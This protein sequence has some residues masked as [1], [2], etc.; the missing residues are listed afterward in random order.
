LAYDVPKTPED[1][2]AIARVRNNEY[3]TRNL[4]YTEI[5]WAI[6]GKLPD[7]FKPLFADETEVRLEIRTLRTAD[8]D[9]TALT[10]KV[11][12]IEVAA[13]S[14]S[15]AA[16]DKDEKVE[17][18]AYGWNHGSSMRGGQEM[19]S[20]M[21]QL[22]RHQVRFGDGC[23]E[24]LPDHD[25]KLV[26]FNVVDPRNH[27]Y[28]IGYT[29]W[30]LAPL[31]GTLIVEKRPLGWLKATYPDSAMALSNQYSSYKRG[32]G[33]QD[34][35]DHMCHV[36]RYYHSDAWYVTTLEEDPVILARSEQGID[37]G[38]PG[39]CP[40]VSLQQF[41]S[42]P[43]FQGQIGIEMA[44]QKVLSQ[45]IQAT[46]Q[47]LH[48]PIVGPLIQNGFKWDEYNVVDQSTY[49]GAIPQLQRLAPDNPLNTERVMGSLM[50]LAR[51][52]NRNP[53]SFQ[54]GGDA[55]SAKAVQTLQSGVRSTV[56]DIL[57][58]PF[59]SG[60]PRVY[61]ICIAI[62]QALWP[63]ERK[64]AYGKKGKSYFETDYTPS[65][66]LDGYEGRIKIEQGF[67]LGGY[68]A[69]LEGQQ[70]VTGGLMPR[71]M[72]YEMYPGYRD[73]GAIEQMLDI[74]KLDDLMFAVA[75]AKGPA[76]TLTGLAEVRKRIEE[77]KS[78]GEAFREVEKEGLLEPPAPPAMPTPGAEGMPPELAA[79]MGS[80]EE[81]LGA[82]VS[83]SAARGF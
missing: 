77:G 40:V 43:L 28:P 79:M 68:Q 21:F 48:G 11:F 46:S 33:N 5:E 29:P 65:V 71:R 66:H 62:E 51:V 27:L 2:Y 31:D 75:E 82:P 6:K 69:T 54:G 45:E 1:L 63:N 53:E 61:D 56:Q 18:I 39:I 16:K 35:D 70:L 30:G 24:V 74:Q 64:K 23:I 59:K 13:R 83:L 8:D 60:F 36:G 50:G 38:H 81:E 80:G 20:I 10:A 58:A 32:F 7:R 12:P 22:A 3:A 37:K 19:D 57:W 73:A 44:L 17:Q 42:D 15:K 34:A 4:S 72:F 76:L 14:Q 25:R 41:S 52:L 67:G 49:T 26:F 9:L 55:N 78:A 47:M